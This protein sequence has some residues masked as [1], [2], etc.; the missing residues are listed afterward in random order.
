[1]KGVGS[2]VGSGSVSQGYGSGDR[3]GNRTKMSRIP[4]TVRDETNLGQLRT[5]A[6]DRCHSCCRL[7]QAVQTSDLLGSEVGSASFRLLFATLLFATTLLLLFV[8]KN[9]AL[10]RP[11]GRKFSGSAQSRRRW[12]WLAFNWRQLVF[13]FVLA[14]PL[15]LRLSTN[16]LLRSDNYRLFCRNNCHRGSTGSSRSFFTVFIGSCC[17]IIR[18]SVVE[19]EPEPEPEP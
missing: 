2:R 4:N 19:P 5:N 12:Y 16:S 3:I 18:A 6:A 10:S 15:S 11:G 1:M 14:F 9:L 7:G 17:I 8:I 13:V